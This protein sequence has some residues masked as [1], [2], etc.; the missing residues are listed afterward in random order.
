MATILFFVKLNISGLTPPQLVE[1]ARALVIAL[2]GNAAFPTPTPTT[3]AITAGA[4]ALEVAEAAVINNGGRQDYL[5]RNVRERELRD[6]ITLLG[7]YVQVTSGG[8][9]EK[10]LSAG[11]QTRKEATPIGLLPAPQ[12]LRALATTM[13]GVIDLRW[14]RVRG[15][16]IYVLQIN[17]GDPLVEVDWVNLVL[18]GRNAYS[19]TGLT[20]GKNISFRV[21]A[22]GAAGPGPWSDPAIEKPK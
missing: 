13:P 20:S 12:N 8:D 10:I 18:L 2:T 11:F 4:D 3:A 14:E 16:L 6:L 21:Q 22:I 1:R 5:T 19:A 7:S 17:T 15:R 9:P